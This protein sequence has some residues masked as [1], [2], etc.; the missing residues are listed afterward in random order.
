M[1]AAQ[2]CNLIDQLCRFLNVVL[3]SITTSALFCIILSSVNICLSLLLRYIALVVHG[4]GDDPA[5]GIA[6]PCGIW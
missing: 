6:L 3:R 1:C 4:G 5:A 2:L